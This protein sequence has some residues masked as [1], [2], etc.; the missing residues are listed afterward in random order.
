[1]TQEI[2]QQK[3]DIDKVVDPSEVFVPD[4]E[5]EFDLEELAKEEGAKWA[6][7]EDGLFPMLD[8]DPGLQG[9]KE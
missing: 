3:A 1:M 9:P 6:D 2:L 7:K 8:L 5:K 4:H